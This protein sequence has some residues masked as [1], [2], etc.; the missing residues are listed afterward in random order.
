MSLNLKYWC[1]TLL[2]VEVR[3][4]RANLCNFFKPETIKNDHEAAAMREIFVQHK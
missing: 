2:Q 3:D 4:I 1:V